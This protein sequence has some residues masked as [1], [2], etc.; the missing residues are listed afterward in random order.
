MRKRTN[1]ASQRY[2]GWPTPKELE[3]YFLAPPGKQWA[4]PSRNASAGLTG[5]GADGTEHLESGRGRIDIHL[6]MEGNRDLGV[7]LFYR[8]WGGGVRESYWSRGDLT[9]LRECVGTVQGTQLP[10][11]LF[12]PF[13]E[14]W[15]AVSEFI[16]TDGALP[17]SILWIADGDL[18]PD[19]FPHP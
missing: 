10:V 5:E 12:V 9:R 17:R 8:K 16:E 13:E 3:P 19:T 15:K 7:L 14:A 2:D 11:G 1:F 18:P 4:F 6:D